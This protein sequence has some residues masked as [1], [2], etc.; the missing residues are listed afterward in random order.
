M[1]GYLSNIKQALIKLS[2][3]SNLKDIKNSKV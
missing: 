2:I 1:A 3:N